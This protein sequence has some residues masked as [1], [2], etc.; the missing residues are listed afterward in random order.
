MTQRSIESCGV[1][2]DLHTVAL[3]AMDG[4]IDW[5][6]LPK[7]DSPSV[8]AS[9]LDP[10]KGGFFRIA[11][12]H[13]GTNRQMYIPETNVLLTRFMRDEGV[14]E[15]V[16]FMPVQTDRGKASESIMH[17]IVRIARAVRGEVKFCLECAPAF[18]F[19]RTLPT[20][21]LVDGGV[22][23]DTGTERM[24]LLGP[25]P[26]R[27]RE[28][29]AFSE[30]TLQPNQ[31]AEF[32]LRY[33]TDHDDLGLKQP[34][35]GD[36][37]LQ[38]T[39]AF[40]RKWISHCTY[41]GRW[42]ED[43]YRSALTLKLLTHHPTGAIVA[44]PTCSLPEEIGGVRNWDYRYTWV[45]DGAFTMYALV[46]LGF[47]EEATAFISWLEDRIHESDGNQG[48]LNTMYRIDGSS[49]LDE[50]TLGHLSGY[51]NSRPVRV[52]NAASRQLQLDIYGEMVDA[53]YLYD[54][55]VSPISYDLWRRIH[56]V[57]MWV[58]ENWDQ[59]DEGLWEVR[60]ERQ[61]FVYSRMQCWVALDRGVRLAEGRSLPLDRERLRN[62]RDRIFN[63]IMAHGWDPEQQSFVQSYES[64]AM[65]ASSLMMPIVMFIAPKDPR[66]LSTLKRIRETLVS[67][68]LVYRYS[69]DGHLAERDGLT[70]REGT[71]SMCTFW[72]VDALARAG[73]V[74]D[75]RLIF[76]K[77]LTYGNHLGLYSEEI[78]STGNQLGNFPQ[79]FTHLGL[80]SAALHLDQKLRR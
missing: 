46:R 13:T 7:F 38:E 16:D 11:P 56:D 79:A 12:E 41:Q 68:S 54:K 37:L 47:T 49:D 42:R 28:G 58:V 25:G 22:L 10:E 33:V 73:Y 3:V 19:A 51:K 72:L 36:R 44:A 77:M 34:V 8:F 64:K 67:D 4:T 39:L 50:F 29:R 66:M 76:E 30:F 55:H 24:V 15:V 63:S 74:D 26:W 32:A 2:G 52:G 59:P 14:G 17:D 18:N 31:T 69:L 1:I 9:L 53:I 20:V 6:C 61:H 48:P 57:L 43:V 23:F 40:W 80:I 75:A 71:F 62:E 21:E 65:D 35:D 5:C 60:S 70:G 78:G 45:R 27:I